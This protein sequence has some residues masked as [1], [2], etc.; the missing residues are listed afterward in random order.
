[1]S[2]SHISTTGSRPTATSQPD[3]SV[4]VSHSDFSRIIY[5]P[6]NEERVSFKVMSKHTADADANCRVES[7]RRSRVLNSQ[8]VVVVVELPRLLCTVVGRKPA[9][10][11]QEGDDIRRF[12]LGKFP[13]RQERLPEGFPSP[14]TPRRT[15][16]QQMFSV[17][18]CFARFTFTTSRRL[19]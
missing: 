15:S 10:P 13:V 2:Q 4:N 6:N 16:P 1:M 17:F 19:S 8:L 14:L 18:F 12:R 3:T 11:P 9:N 7:R 5:R